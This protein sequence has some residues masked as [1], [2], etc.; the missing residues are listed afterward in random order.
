MDTRTHVAATL[1]AVLISHLLLALAVAAQEPTRDL[2]IVAPA[3]PGGGWDQTARVMQLALRDAGLA[4]SVQVINIPG[5]AGT[6]G[7]A[8]FI[9][10]ERGNENALLVTGLV[11]VGGIVTNRS[12]I[13][14]ADVTPIA[15]LTGEYEVLV[16]PAASPVRT[17]RQLIDSLARAPQAVSWG[18]G[19][20]GGTDEILMRLIADKVGRTGN[21][22]AYS[23]GGQALAAVL[24]GHVTVGVSGLS[25][26]LPHI[27]SG[28]L[29]ALAV[30]A[31]TRVPGVDIPT[32]REQGI[33]VDLLNWRG[34]VAPP[35]L[36]RA[37]R[38]SLL[39]VV[40]RM[41]RTPQWGSAMTRAG[42]TDIY[43]EGDGFARFV[44][45][46]SQRVTLVMRRDAPA[47][48]GGFERF[49]LAGFALAIVAAIVQASRR[50]SDGPRVRQSNHPGRTALTLLATGL[51]LDVLLMQWAGFVLAS[52][53]LFVFVARA[54]GSRR[55]LRDVAVA[56]AIALL[57]HLGFTRGLGVTLPGFFG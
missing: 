11:M 54:F 24:G 5:A 31:P 19:S 30:S 40:R 14:L 9:S 45:D 52:A 23:G 13:S 33:E 57:V 53:V 56:V 20:A 17:L 15:R 26:F 10:A 7:L 2:T 50:R 12:P 48:S 43:M 4:R 25:E 39:G 6:V 27:Q 41:T 36:S 16:V 51:V 49:V 29:R 35:G 28:A 22:I 37:Q 21:Y 32:L 1:P 3:A 55:P 47:G 8:R 42:W 18:G 34:V 38:D 44:R 46:E